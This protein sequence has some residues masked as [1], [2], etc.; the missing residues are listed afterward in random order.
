[1]SKLLDREARVRQDCRQIWM[2]DDAANMIHVLVRNDDER[3]ARH[4]LSHARIGIR[5]K[6]DE[7]VASQ[8][9]TQ[10]RIND[11]C[12]PRIDQPVA[13]NRHIALRPAIAG[14]DRRRGKAEGSDLFNF[15]PFRLVAR[16]R[17]NH[18]TD[19]AD[20]ERIASIRRHIAFDD[21]P[22]VASSLATTN[23]TASPPSTARSH[24]GMIPSPNYPSRVSQT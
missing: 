8:V 19:L 6:R 15:D 17:G 14:D 12:S 5:V 24:L 18:T 2:L 3:C 11:D 20:I 4:C 13:E 9:R 16:Y 23:R 10:C 7:I 1:M 22:I 21:E